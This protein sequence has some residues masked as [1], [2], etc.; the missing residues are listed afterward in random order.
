MR[1]K[2]NLSEIIESQKQNWIL[3][4]KRSKE[5]V[6]LKGSRLQELKKRE[7]LLITQAEQTLI[8]YF[9]DLNEAYYDSKGEIK[10]IPLSEDPFHAGTERFAHAYEPYLYGWGKVNV[11]IRI[12]LH[13][14]QTELPSC[15]FKLK[16]VEG[17][18]K[19]ELLVYFPDMPTRVDTYTYFFGLIKTKGLRE[20]DDWRI[21]NLEEPA[22]LPKVEKY[23]LE[24]SAKSNFFG[25]AFLIR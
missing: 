8:P 25:T 1:F 21:F 19:Q 24:M 23:L 4:D 16:E 15:F 10:I 22:T 3:A 7:K 5:W 2:E 20:G 6:E 9:K 17:K 14:P 18:G 11:E 13:R 12:E